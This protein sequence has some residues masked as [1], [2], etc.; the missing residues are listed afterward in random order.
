MNR[1]GMVFCPFYE[2]KVPSLKT[3]DDH[4]Y[5]FGCGATG[6]C[7]GVTAKL[8]AILQLEAS[9]KIRYDFEMNLFVKEIAVPI[10]VK[11]NP[12]AEYIRQKLRKNYFIRCL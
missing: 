12:D 2:D 9:K 3:Y 1:S 6:D 7:I 5:C 10:K 4:Y 11:V 8:F